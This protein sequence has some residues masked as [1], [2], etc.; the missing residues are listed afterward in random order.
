MFKSRFLK[1]KK[2]DDDSDEDA[3]YGSKRHDLDE[4]E[5]EPHQNNDKGVGPS[6]NFFKGINK[7]GSKKKLFGKKEKKGLFGR[8][9]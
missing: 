2:V 1:K 3:V 7:E 6:Q 5:D 9:K 8:K 4:D